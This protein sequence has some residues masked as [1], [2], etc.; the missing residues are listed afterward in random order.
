MLKPRGIGADEAAVLRQIAI[1]GEPA[2][3]AVPV[4]LPRIEQCFD[5]DTLASLRDHISHTRDG[6]LPRQAFK[7][8]C[9]WRTPTTPRQSTTCTGWST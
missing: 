1:R 5:R 9:S 6:Q 7:N 4:R 2:Q 3:A 8:T